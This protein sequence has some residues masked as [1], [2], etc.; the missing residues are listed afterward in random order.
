M[1]EDL[2]EDAMLSGGTYYQD[3]NV[4]YEAIALARNAPRWLR[5]LEKHGFI[6]APDAA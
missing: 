6:P 1:E 2:S 3:R 5:I 4:D